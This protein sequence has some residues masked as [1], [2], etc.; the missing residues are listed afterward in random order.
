MNVPKTYDCSH[1]SGGYTCSPSN[2]QGF[3]NIPEMR[4]STSIW[5]GSTFFSEEALNPQSNYWDIKFSGDTPLWTNW[6]NNGHGFFS[7]LAQSCSARA[8]ELCYI[9]RTAALQGIYLECIDAMPSWND[10]KAGI[11]QLLYKGY[12]DQYGSSSAMGQQFINA[13]DF[14]NTNDTNL[15]V[16]VMY[17]DTTQWASPTGQPKSALR[18]MAP[19]STVFDAYVN[20]KLGGSGYK[21]ALSALG[22]KEMPQP[23]WKLNLDLASSLG[24]FF[25]TLAF[26]LLLPTIIVSIVYE[27]EMKLR[28]SPACLSCLTD[29]HADDG[30]GKCAILVHQLHLLVYHIRALCVPAPPC[31]LVGATAVRLHDRPLHQAGAQRALRLLLLVL[32]QHHRLRLPV[33][34]TPAISPHL[35]HRSHTLRPRLLAHRVALLGHRELL[36]LHQRVQGPGQLHHP[37]PP[38]ELVPR[39]QRVLP[40]R[41]R[42]HSLGRAGADVEQDGHGPSVLARAEAGARLTAG[43]VW[44]ACSAGDPGGGVGDFHAHHP[45]PRPGR[46]RRKGRSRCDLLATDP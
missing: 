40:V 21:Y 45:V 35:L 1:G 11:N 5:A 13:Y 10:N 29:H 43:Q 20:V 31:R 14:L 42:R 33:D 17:N 26:S 41:L 36:Q 23:A 22:I 9:N 4:F 30:A 2:L 3:F 46:R 6:G 8:N 7:L 39:V 32:Q 38:L 19:L 25:F 24:P 28:V 18:I 16:S 44:D 12:Y 15:N 27:K 37:L 34:D